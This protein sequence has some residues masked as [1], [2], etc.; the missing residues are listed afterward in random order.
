MINA[1][2]AMPQ[3]K[4]ECKVLTELSALQK[5]SHNEVY[6][7]AQMVNLSPSMGLAEWM[8]NSTLDLN[9]VMRHD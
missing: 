9:T 4:V 7:D 5:G 1:A 6:R 3:A 8:E 2:P